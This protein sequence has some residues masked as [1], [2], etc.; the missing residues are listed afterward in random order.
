LLLASRRAAPLTG[1]ADKLAMWLHWFVS[2]TP[3]LHDF[4]LAKRQRSFF[5]AGQGSGSACLRWRKEAL[6]LAVYRA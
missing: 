4:Y 3:G 1:S 5:D 6:A 2:N